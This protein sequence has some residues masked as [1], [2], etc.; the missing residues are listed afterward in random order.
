MET[1]KFADFMEKRS[2][3]EY[4]ES[5]SFNET[6]MSMLIAM[7]IISFA[8]YVIRTFAEVVRNVFVGVGG[9]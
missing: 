9:M 1:I 2:F 6:L 5:R 3:G 7:F 8:P 4:K